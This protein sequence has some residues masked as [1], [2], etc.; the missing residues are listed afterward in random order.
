MQTQE[1]K[2]KDRKEEVQKLHKK[3]ER[4]R[5]KSLNRKDENPDD[6]QK[7]RAQMSPEARESLQSIGMLFQDLGPKLKLESEETSPKTLEP[8]ILTQNEISK[9]S[10]EGQKTL[11]KFGF[12][13]IEN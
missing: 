5:Q 3:V 6:E 4:I 10:P 1:K 12:L 9:I 7:E 8:L 2:Q 13:E 11:Q